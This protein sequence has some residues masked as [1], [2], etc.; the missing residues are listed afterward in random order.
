MHH[1]MNYIHNFISY[2]SLPSTTICPIC[3]K[4]C[5][6][7]EYKRVH[8]SKV[9]KYLTEYKCN[10]CLPTFDQPYHLMYS[11]AHLDAHTEHVHSKGEKSKDSAPYKCIHC[12]SAKFA[13]FQC[14]QSSRMLEHVI[15]CHGYSCAQC[16]K[17]FS[18]TAGLKYHYK[19]AHFVE[20]NELQS[21]HAE[22]DVMHGYAESILECTIK[23]EEIVNNEGEFAGGISL[24][25]SIPPATINSED[26]GKYKGVLV[27]E[28]TEV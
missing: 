20:E 16:P 10:Q 19:K 9:H 21:D 25:N 5:K 6:T 1:F 8:I 27:T 7:V 11:Q 14:K 26:K 3:A 28:I 15:T 13:I 23:S 24:N 2:F 17:H 18:T 22:D 4:D 12:K